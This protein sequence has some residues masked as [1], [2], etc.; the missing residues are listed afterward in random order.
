MKPKGRDVPPRSGTDPRTRLPG[1]TR[2]GQVYVSSGY[3]MNSRQPF[4]EIELPGQ[5]PIQLEVDEA[6]FVAHLILEACEA[7]EQDGALTEW[8]QSTRGD[9]SEDERTTMAAMM[10]REIRAFREKRRNKA[11]T[12]SA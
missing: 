9:V 5:P 1:E 8:V 2:L 12:R 6:R 10:L 3:G 4:V 11:R 7:A